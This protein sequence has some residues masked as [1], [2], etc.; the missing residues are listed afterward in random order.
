VDQHDNVSVTVA[1]SKEMW[2]KALELPH[3]H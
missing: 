2:V 1:V 3:A